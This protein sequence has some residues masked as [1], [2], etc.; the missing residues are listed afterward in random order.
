MIPRSVHVA[1]GKLGVVGI[2]GLLRGIGSWGN[3]MP[4]EA[5]TDDGMRGN[6]GA[7]SSGVVWVPFRSARTPVT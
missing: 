4:K 3:V 2:R 5:H 7:K 1:E 6:E